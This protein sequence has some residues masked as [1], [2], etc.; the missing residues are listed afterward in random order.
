[1]H[2]FSYSVERLQGQL[3]AVARMGW[4]S[5]IGSGIL[6][7]GCC[8]FVASGSVGVW[9]RLFLSRTKGLQI[10]TEYVE[11]WAFPFGEESWFWDT[12]REILHFVELVLHYYDAMLPSASFF[13]QILQAQ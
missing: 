4:G 9:G 8:S 3:R 10:F 7:L 11:G 12:L 2:A 1:M 6:D 13:V 5:M